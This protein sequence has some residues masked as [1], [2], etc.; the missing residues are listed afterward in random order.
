MESIKLARF[1]ELWAAWPHHGHDELSQTL[2]G[3]VGVALND[4]TTACGIDDSLVRLSTAFARTGHAVP[5][6][7]LHSGA[8]VTDREGFRHLVEPTSATLFLE[9]KLGKPRQVKSE[10]DILGR[11]GILLF[12]GL[13]K[14][15][16]DFSHADLWNGSTTSDP[17]SAFWKEAAHVA[18]FTLN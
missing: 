3:G 17:R 9:K 4:S 7:A 6:G 16:V 8:E 18:V 15:G 11:S 1:A 12:E 10:A 2:G 5:A 13:T 14:Q